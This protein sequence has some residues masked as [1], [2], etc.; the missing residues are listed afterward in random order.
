MSLHPHFRLA[1]IYMSV[2]HAA[3]PVRWPGDTGRGTG[4][5][6]HRCVDVQRVFLRCMTSP[7][8]VEMRKMSPWIACSV[9]VSLGLACGGVEVA[10][11]ES[12]ETCR[13]LVVRV[14][15]APAKFDANLLARLRACTTTTLGEDAGVSPANLPVPVDPLPLPGKD[16]SSPPTRRY[17]DWSPSAP[18][19]G[20]WPSPSPWER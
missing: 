12:P 19:K 14:V 16:A 9:C 11:A 17:G 6:H 5:H 3:T 13:N 18:W 20:D 7:E 2:S 1:A 15:D 10:A 8:D 4:G